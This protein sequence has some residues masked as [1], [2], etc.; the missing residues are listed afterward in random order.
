MLAPPEYQPIS[1][2]GA[3]GNLRTVAL[4][5][6]HGSVDWCCFPHLDSTS[7][8]GALLDRLQGGRFL[9]APS[10]ASSSS[11]TYWAETN[12]LDTVFE[13]T[14]G[15]LVITDWM[16][17]S[18]NI[19]GCG[20]STAPPVILRR[21]RCEGR[22]MEVELI[23]SPRFDYARG[24]TSISRVAGG[25]LARGSNGEQLVL[26]ETFPNALIED[27]GAGPSVW[28]RFT[29]DPNRP[30]WLE[31]RWAADRADVD[32][33]A[34]LDSLETTAEVWRN[35]TRKG[36][37]SRVR[38]WA[39]AHTDLILRSELALRL[40]T[41]GETGA[42]AAAATTSLPEDIGGVRNWDYRFTW[43]RD[44][45]QLIESLMAMGHRAEVEDFLN[46]VEHFSETGPDHS[47]FPIMFGL[48]G[49][50][51]S[52]ERKLSHLEGY[53]KSRP[54]RIG[55]AGF[56]QVQHDV[57]GEILNSGYEF[58]RLGEKL[59]PAMSRFLSRAADQACIQWREPDSGL[60][61]IPGPQRHYVYSKMMTWV[62]L[63]RAVHLA[64]RGHLR[65]NAPRWKRERD[66]IK[67]AI[68]EQGY[69]A[70]L[71][72]FVLAFGSKELDGA[73]LLIPMMEFLPF[74]DPRVQSTINR[75]MERLATDDF[76]FRYVADDGIP[77]EEGAFGLVTF[78]MADALAFSG[79]L[80]EAHRFFD[81][82]A[83][84]ANHVGLFSEQVDP[85]TREQL[86]NM[87]QAFT[88]IGLIDT[89]IH[90]AHV[91]GR[92]TPIEAPIGSKEHRAELGRDG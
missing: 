84:C 92:E 6:L 23:W 85:R 21:L 54:V 48:H 90:L 28:A 25:F 46:F 58:V 22:P 43:V 82:M 45:S 47:S 87:P 32:P 37:A 12:I 34:C 62:A 14:S 49:Q 13:T 91:E 88:H 57:Y 26:G 20:K 60:W 38:E 30:L 67:A 77:G 24:K 86:G 50:T 9:V 78:W 44:A 76:V 81:N 18:G 5:G 19:D 56:Q 53:R 64:E 70:E 8:F 51:D 41:H 4:V 68:L 55:N 27:D 7:V 36:Q 35:W 79:R 2:Y 3:I 69:S 15:R 17:I 74:E 73:N 80:D 89:A 83:R 40:L 63:D 11:Q 42:M 33:R 65:G 31:T 1:G 52:R 75:T 16:P 29:V 61:E 10:T 59:S 71:G 66:M 72:A 39:A